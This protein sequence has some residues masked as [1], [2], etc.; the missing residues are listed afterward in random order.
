MA[1]IQENTQVQEPKNDKEYNFRM[2]ESKL[3]EERN[4]RLE[5]E[6]K[7][8]EALRIAKEIQEKKSISDDDDDDD[9]YISPKKLDKKLNQYNQI[10]RQQ[11]QEEVNRAVSLALQEEK[12]Q[13]WLKQNSD[14]YDV[15]NNHA[16]KFHDMDPELA[17]TILSM[18]DTFERQKLVYKNIK[19]L[20][21][22]RPKN[23]EP[24]IQNTIDKNRKAPFYQP[25]SLPNGPVDLSKSDFSPEGQKR[26][27]EK[28]KQLQGGK[29][30]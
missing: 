28:M 13:S 4:A 21:I 2:L 20:G 17:E 23:P 7:A 8:E 30:W 24:S 9:D 6:K 27:Y 5:A 18:P 19:A 26:A 14:F 1:E 16:Q 15:L 10:S 12:K 25:T 22:D 3:R 29:R 11:T